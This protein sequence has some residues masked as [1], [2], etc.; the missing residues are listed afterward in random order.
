MTTNRTTKRT[1][2]AVTMTRNAAA[3]VALVPDEPEVVGDDGGDLAPVVPPCAF[4]FEMRGDRCPVAVFNAPDA[5]NT[6]IAGGDRGQHSLQF[7][8][9]VL[10][11]FSE[12]DAAKVRKASRGNAYVEAN[13]RLADEPLI[14]S[15]CFPKTRWYSQNAYERH[16]SRFHSV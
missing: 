9:G 5:W 3:P 16:M 8:R 13:P 14:C 11:V 4:P 6:T 12:S 1:A 2:Q 7:A 10:A 15:K